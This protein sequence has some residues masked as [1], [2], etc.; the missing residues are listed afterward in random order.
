MLCFSAECVLFDSRHTLGHR[1]SSHD[2]GSSYLAPSPS[3]MAAILNLHFAEL[4]GPGFQY[5]P[6]FGLECKRSVSSFSEKAVSSDCINPS[7]AKATF[8]QSTRTQ[9][10]L[11]DDFKK[12]RKLQFTFNRSYRKFSQIS[13]TFY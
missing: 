1:M 5:K 8:V 3:N 4:E 11:D 7:N 12:K 9:R 10:C 2:V 6:M 13:D